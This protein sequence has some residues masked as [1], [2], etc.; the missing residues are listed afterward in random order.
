[1]EAERWSGREMGS[2]PQLSCRRGSTA[3]A[4]TQGPHSL[5]GVRRLQSTAPHHWAHSDTS[6]RGT[7]AHTRTHTRTHT[8]TRTQPHT[9]PYPPQPPPSTHPPLMSLSPH[10]LP[11]DS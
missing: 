7:P 4:H 3:P 9:Y 1:G 2:I 5:S 6:H 10:T 11:R 8:D